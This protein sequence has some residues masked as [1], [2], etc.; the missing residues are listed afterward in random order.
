MFQDRALKSI[1]SK[2]FLIIGQLPPPVHGSNSMTELLYNSVKKIGYKVHILQKTFSKR[3]EDVGRIS[4]IKLL[5]VPLIAAHL[6]CHLTK[7]KPD[8]CFYFIS[9]KPPSFFVDAFFIL[10]IRLF[11]CK[12]VLYLHGKGLLDLGTRS[13]RLLQFIVLKTV[14]HSLGAIVLGERL[15]LDVNRF[16]PD[17]RLFV[18]PNAIEDVKPEKIKISYHSQKS[19]KILF[20][21]NLKP[22]KGPMEF[23]KMAKI[24]IDNGKDVRFILAGSPRLENFQKKL[25][26]YIRQEGLSNFIEIPGGVYGDAK[27]RLFYDSDVFVFPTYYENETFGLVN[28]EAMRAGLP[29]ISSSEGSIPE[30]VIDGINGYIVDP[31]NHEQMADRVLSLVENPELRKKM[32]RAGR[33]IYEKF[34][35]IQVY[36]TRLKEIISLLI[37][38]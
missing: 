24:L 11:R 9:V 12:F 26:N 23:L 8:L 30:V 14:S 1:T 27:E 21:S 31:K 13:G 36:E 32:G 3:L 16:I 5:K 10:L 20:L 35:T 6:V 2:R 33:E 18:L 17:E 28:L 4:I 15:K 34:F 25:R 38:L 19:V 37:T 29:V 7:N 22:S